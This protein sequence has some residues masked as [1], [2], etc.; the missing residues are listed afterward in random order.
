VRNFIDTMS[1]QM[2]GFHAE[3]LDWGYETQETAPSG[4]AD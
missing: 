2:R 1:D 4:E 3:L